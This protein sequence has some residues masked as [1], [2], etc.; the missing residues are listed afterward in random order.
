MLFCERCQH[1]V[2]SGQ[3]SR[4]EIC[5]NEDLIT[6]DPSTVVSPENI[7]FPK[8]EE[9]G[10]M[11]NITVSYD[12]NR[13][14]LEIMFNFLKNKHLISKYA[15]IYINDYCVGRI[16]IKI[17]AIQSTS[18]IFQSLQSKIDSIYAVMP[19]N[20]SAVFWKVILNS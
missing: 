14:L 9:K 18:V 5:H 12:Q 2:F 13:K 7:L 10:Y 3:L 11:P 19:D 6:I 17:S 15:D 16:N 20:N 8:E 1:I 4:C